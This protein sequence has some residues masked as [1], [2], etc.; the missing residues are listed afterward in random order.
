MRDSFFN[1]VRPPQN[2]LQSI[3]THTLLRTIGRIYSSIMRCYILANI[4]E[5]KTCVDMCRK[6]L[7]E[8]MLYTTYKKIMGIQDGVS[9]LNSYQ[10]F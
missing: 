3:L 8:I 7:F 1:F 9:F 4:S 10:N 2:D 5:T 6:K